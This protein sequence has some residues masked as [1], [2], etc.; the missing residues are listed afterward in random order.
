MTAPEHTARRALVLTLLARRTG[1]DA[2]AEAIATA[3]GAVYGDLAQ[4]LEPVIGHV[5]VAAM[6][7]RALHLSTGAYAWLPSRETGAADPRFTQV[8]E[9][10]KRQEPVLATEA[11]ATVLAAILGLLATFIGEPLTAR[12]VRQAWPDVPSSADTQET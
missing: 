3:A 12:L 10:L 4:V 6:T 2:G 7:D 5:G 11:A 8:I 1:P 9:A